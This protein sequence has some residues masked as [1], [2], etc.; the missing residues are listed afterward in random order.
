[1][2]NE[3]AFNDLQDYRDYSPTPFD[4]KGLMG[5]DH[6]IADFKVLLGRNRDSDPLDE[7]NFSVALDMLGGESESVQVHSFGHWACG[8]LEIILIYPRDKRAAS[9]AGE[10]A[11]SLSN[12]PILD[13][14]D[15][16]ERELEAAEQIWRNCYSVEDRKEYIREHREQFEFRGLAEIKECLRGEC[17][18]GYASELIY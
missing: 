5:D 3:N 12:Y 15:Y 7:S 14:F 16:S 9:I 2:K 13:E 4:S 6:G 11:E 8:W 18:R 17:F 1:M 10:I